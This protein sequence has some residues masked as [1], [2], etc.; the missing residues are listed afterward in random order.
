V[1]IDACPLATLFATHRA[2]LL[3]CVERRL[4]PAL[5]ARASADDMLQDAY[6][7]AKRD[8]DLHGKLPPPGSEF[9]WLFRTVLD[10][11][12]DAWRRAT[13]GLRDV[14]MD[15]GRIDLSSFGL[16]P[17]DTGT[18]PATASERAEMNGAVHE[19]MDGLKPEYREVLLLH[20]LDGLTLRET[21]ELLGITENNAGVRYARAAQAFKQSWQ[22]RFPD[23]IGR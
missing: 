22:G 3:A 5:R 23:G 18:G 4:Q 17:I 19:V 6:L 1:T 21:G 8:Y 15:Q 14:R 16:A 7:S 12:A 9:P 20:G 10:C 2:R 11:I 13:A